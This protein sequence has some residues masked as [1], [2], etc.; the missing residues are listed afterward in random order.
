MNFNIEATN[1]DTERRVCRAKLIAEEINKSFEAKKNYKAL[2]FG[3]GT[4]LISFNLH[5]KF[6]KVTLVDTSQGMIDMLNW[7]IQENNIKNMIACKIDTNKESM[8]TEKYDVIYTSMALHHVL[9]IEATLENLYKLLNKDGYLCI[10]DLDEED[11]SFH[12]DEK[13]FKGYNGFNQRELSNLLEKIGYND[14]QSNIIYSDAKIISSGKINY[15]LFLMT[16]RK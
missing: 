12:S 13:D 7:K 1:W 5:H 2:E 16:G 9:D 11:G 6:E 8:L 14:V 3:C 15:S 4:G 10:V